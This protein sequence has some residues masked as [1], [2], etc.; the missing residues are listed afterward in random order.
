M[1]YGYRSTCL[2]FVLLLLF[3]GSALAHKVNLF[4]HVESG[5]VYTESYFPDG[6]PVTGGKVLVY[7]PAE[8]LLLE[9]STDKDGLFSFAIPGI[10]ELK[11]V[12][13]ATMGHRNSFK[14][15]KSELEEG[16]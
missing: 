4:A 15:K 3:S 8:T 10:V 6:R 2:A 9:G 7:D 11:I 5:Q 12:I 13:E 16:Q 1:K 14:L